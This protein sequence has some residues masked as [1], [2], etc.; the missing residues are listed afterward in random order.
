MKKAVFLVFVFLV[1][2]CSISPEKDN[3]VTE[4]KP[5]LT[6]ELKQQRELV[7]GTWYSNQNTDNGGSREEIA[8]YA[9][10]GKYRLDFKHTKSD[11]SIEYSREVGYW[12][13][14]GNIFFSIFVGQIVDGKLYQANPED[15]YND[16]A[17]KIDEL[18]KESFIYEHVHTGN[19]FKSIRV[20][21]DFKFNDVI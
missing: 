1:S 7:V 8:R 11:G 3:P 6:D 18:N 2:A 4:I 16:D 9:R 14:S 19:H 21:D 15:A 5:A 17:Y 20:K 12:G 10:D 13:V